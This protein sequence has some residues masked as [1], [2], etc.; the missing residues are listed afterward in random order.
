MGVAM[1]RDCATWCTTSEYREPDYPGSHAARRRKGGG[2]IGLVLHVVLVQCRGYDVESLSSADS[3]EV[4]GGVEAEDFA[5]ALFFGE[6]YQRGIRE[7][8]G[9][10]CVH[11]HELGSPAPKRLL[12]IIDSE[13]ALGGIGGEAVEETTDEDP[14]RVALVAHAISAHLLD[15][16]DHDLAHWQALVD[17]AERTPTHSAP[18]TGSLI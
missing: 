13:H 18:K 5:V 14:A 2:G 17:Q 6:C 11:V 9:S 12:T 7:V 8:H 15:A 1:I 3:V 10:V 16:L 4:E